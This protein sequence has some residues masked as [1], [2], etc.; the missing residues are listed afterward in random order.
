MIDVA[1]VR[2]LHE[3][4]GPD[5]RREDAMRLWEP[6]VR[7]QLLVEETRA[8]RQALTLA[9]NAIARAMMPR[10]RTNGAYRLGEMACFYQARQV[11]C[12]GKANRA[13][14]DALFAEPELHSSSGPTYQYPLATFSGIAWREPVTD[15]NAIDCCRQCRYLAECYESVVKRDGFAWCEVVLESELI[16]EGALY[17]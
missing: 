1:N 5:W 6:E 15:H 2:P 9:L 17:G 16:P 7:A 10:R 13:Q 4:F 12:V 14:L 3:I 11:A 8:Q